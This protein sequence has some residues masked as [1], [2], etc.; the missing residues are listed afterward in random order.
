MVPISYKHHVGPTCILRNFDVRKEQAL[1]LTIFDALQATL[2][3]PPLF[4]STTIFK[5]ASTFEYIAA[6]LTLSNPTREIIA[7]ANGIFGGEARVACILGVGCGHPGVS[8][9]PGESDLASWNSLLERLATDSEQQAQNIDAQMGHLG[10]YYRFCVTR[11]LESAEVVTL[12]DAGILLTHTA[13]Y[14]SDVAIS[15]KLT[16]CVDTLKLRDGVASLYQLSMSCFPPSL[17]F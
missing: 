10:L 17:F 2:A 14:L 12:S 11:G 1:N 5:D 4:A 9:V 13:V 15:R 8:K 7:E 16:V 6:D 3:T